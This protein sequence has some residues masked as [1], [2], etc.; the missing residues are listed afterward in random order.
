MRIPL[1]L[2]CVRFFLLHQL[3]PSIKTLVILAIKNQVN[4][5]Y[6]NHPKTQNKQ[7]RNFRCVQW[8]VFHNQC[9]IIARSIIRRSINCHIYVLSYLLNLA[10][11]FCLSMF[12]RIPVCNSSFGSDVAW[13]WF[14]SEPS[15]SPLE[16][17]PPHQKSF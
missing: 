9:S 13:C 8:I 4:Q 15:R 11:L 6:Q 12:C 14:W 10:S 7:T 2:R 17:T 16:A 1:V 3:G 5:L